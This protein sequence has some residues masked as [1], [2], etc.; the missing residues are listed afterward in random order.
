MG[1]WEDKFEESYPQIE[2]SLKCCIWYSNNAMD[3]DV[4]IIITDNIIV[5][6]NLFQINSSE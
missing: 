2:I 3:Y 1:H 5:S 4:L 6:H